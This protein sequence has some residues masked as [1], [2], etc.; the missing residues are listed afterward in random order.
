[1]V[2]ISANKPLQE[3]PFSNYNQTPPLWLQKLH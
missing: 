3:S 1:M 2:L